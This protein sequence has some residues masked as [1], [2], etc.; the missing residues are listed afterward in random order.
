MV[1]RVNV[2]LVCGDGESGR[3]LREVVGGLDCIVAYDSSAKSFDP[4]ALALSSA[5]VVV[6]DLTPDAEIDAIYDLIGDTRYRVVFNEAEV[7][8][9][10]SGWDHARWA[11]HL[12]AKILDAPAAVDPPRPDDLSKIGLVDAGDKVAAAG[13]PASLP[14]RSNPESGGP[15]HG[16]ELG[17][18]DWLNR[19]I[20]DDDPTRRFVVQQGGDVLAEQELA[21]LSGNQ[22]I[23]RMLLTEI[24]GLGDAGAVDSSG[25]EAESASHADW[26][27]ESLIATIDEWLPPMVSEPEAGAPKRDVPVEAASTR[28]EWSLVD[29]FDALPVPVAPSRP[30]PQADSRWARPAAVADALSNA[31]EAPPASGRNVLELAPIDDG[32]ARASP[33]ASRDPS[34][35]TELRV[36]IVADRS[37]ISRV[38]V[39]CAS[40]GGPEAIRQILGKLPASYPAA[41]LVVQQVGE[42]FMDMLT[43]QLRRA[44]SLRVRGVDAGDQLRDG[45]VVPVSP[46]QQLIVER[47]GRVSLHQRADLRTTGTSMAQLLRDVGDRFKGA[48]TALVLSGTASDAADGCRHLAMARGRVYVQAPA[49]CVASAMVEQVQ[50]TGVVTFIGTPPE[51]A[52]QLLADIN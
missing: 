25:V 36:D 31:V 18:D 45:D 4:A 24:E 12:A 47:D 30:V 51:L 20:A 15:R 39:V 44:T 38:I 27:V 46:R 21:E 17:I 2:A 35:S 9:R 6:V 22:A 29:D 13:V 32:L 23:E 1:D 10:L 8:S 14:A 19:V 49:S 33:F 16:S 11:R 52:A 50:Q 37:T 40:V 42:E 28:V 26:D 48:S 7:S 34:A 3:L 41:F 5:S 43:Q